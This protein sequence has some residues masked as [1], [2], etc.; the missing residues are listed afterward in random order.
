MTFDLDLDL[1]L[2]L[3]NMVSSGQISKCTVV[4][5][6][7][8]HKPTSENNIFKGFKA[9]S[10]VTMNKKDPV[11]RISII[12]KQTFWVDTLNYLIQMVQ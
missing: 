11:N 5:I 4:N 9:K 7:L 6:F 10:C 3:T 12:L 2:G 8:T 1:D